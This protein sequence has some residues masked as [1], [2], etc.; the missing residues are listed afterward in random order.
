MIL[1][2][3]K[4]FV[5]STAHLEKAVAM[6]LPTSVLSDDEVAVPWWPSWVRREGWMFY[7]DF[8]YENAPVCLQACVNMAREAGCRWLMLDADA[9]RVASLPAWDW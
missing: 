7:V 2:V 3:D 6:S 5:I 1:H 9:E 8:P 4:V